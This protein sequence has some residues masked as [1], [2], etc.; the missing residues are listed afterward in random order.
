[1]WEIVYNIHIV[2]RGETM[3]TAVCQQLLDR[4]STP[5]ELEKTVSYLTEKIGAF[6]KKRER[7]LIC[8]PDTPGELGWLIG[9]AVERCEGIPFYL[10]ED[11][12][13][14]TMIR[15]AFS[16][17]CGTIVAEPLVLL[18]LSK[19]TKAMGV[20]LFIR[21]ALLVGF[22]CMQWMREGIQQGLDCKT[23]GCFDPCGVVAG[24]ISHN[25]ETVRLREDVLD[26]YARDEQGNRLPD[27]ELGEVVICSAAEPGLEVPIE[28][29]GRIEHFHQKDKP[30]AVRM[31]DMAVGRNVEQDIAVL[32]GH[33]HRWTSILDCRVTRG[34]Y[35]LELEIVTFPGEKLPMLPSC[36]KQV[37]RPWDPETEI[38]FSILFKE[39]TFRNH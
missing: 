32:S 3:D 4:M 20:P 27:G 15:T 35:G 26:A 30:D 25:E 23:Y 29:L 19:L 31:A 33:L 36:A 17:R 8:L 37:V 18:G 5:E 16:S 34:F 39:E 7:V 11:R 9:Q 6:L 22:P 12:R 1:M 24:F 28:F 21:N 10:G 14:K 2:E 38:P 13:W